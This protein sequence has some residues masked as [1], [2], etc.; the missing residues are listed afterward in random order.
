MNDATLAELLDRYAVEYVPKMRPRTQR[1]YARHIERLKRDFHGK[2]AKDVQPRDVGRYLDVP[3]GRIH[4]NKLVSLLSTVFQKAIGRW[5]I[6]GVTVNPCAHVE[7]NESH[8]RDRYVTD[9]EFALVKS[10][11]PPVVQLAMDLAYNIGQRQG[12]LLELEW[13]DV[14]SEGVFVQQGKT[15][16]KLLIEMTPALQAIFARAKHMSPQ[17][18]RQYV[19]RTRKG[20]RYMSEGFRAIWQRRMRK[21]HLSGKLPVR[22]TFHDLRAKMVSDSK[23][24]EA[25]SALAGHINTAITRS[26]YDRGVRKVSPLR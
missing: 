25:A 1:D 13:K 16:K 20:R 24:I 14:S 3:K 15:G 21:L 10:V 6:E 12:D 9:A 11:M 7:R 19:I 17:I 23:S 26:V 5:Y 8:P 2:L 22:W 18:P 4:R